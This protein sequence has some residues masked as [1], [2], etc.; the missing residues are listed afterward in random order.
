MNNES[1]PWAI[2]YVTRIDKANPPS[3]EHYCL[4][5]AEATVRLLEH[6]SQDPLLDAAFAEYEKGHIRKFARR[7]NPNTFE[8]LSRLD[9]PHQDAHIGL[10]LTRVYAPAPTDVLAKEIHRLQLTGLTLPSPTGAAP[11]Q[12]AKDAPK[13]T[14]AVNP[15]WGLD[16]HPGKLAAQVAHAAH[17]AYRKNAPLGAAPQPS[18]LLLWPTQAEFDLLKESAPVVIR[19]AGFTVLPQPGVTTIAFW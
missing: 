19:D 16:D 5:H 11:T 18:F 9:L 12:Q 13:V 10:A 6:S 1:A 3:L 14:I 15:K 8:K 4:A 2:Q 7:A 17:I